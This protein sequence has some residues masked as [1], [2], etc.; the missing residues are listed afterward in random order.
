M[1]IVVGTN[2]PTKIAAVKELLQEYPS[3]KDA[4]IVGVNIES[5]VG[6]QPL[7]FDE[8]TTGAVNRARAGFNDCD[9]SIGIEAGFMQV[10]NSKSGYMD[11]T[12]CAVFD[13]TETHLG[14]SSAFETPDKEIMRLVVEDGLTFSEAANKSGLDTDPQV[15]QKSGLIGTLTHGK[16]NRKEFVQQA[17]ITAQIHIDKR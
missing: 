6:E 5:G 4:E 16:I 11:V 14:L 2:N 1:R 3:L 10:P 15:G 13:G 8:V 7:S 9:Y 12:A 17:L